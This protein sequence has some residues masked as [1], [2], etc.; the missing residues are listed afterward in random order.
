MVGHIAVPKLSSDNTPASLS[1]TVITSLLKEELGFDGL[2]V[3]DAL[4]MGALTEN[5][6]NAEIY[7]MTV[8]AGTDLLLMPEDKDLAIKVIKEILN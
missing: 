5:Y 3:T 6:S 2:V 4:D 8:E 1:K 7:K